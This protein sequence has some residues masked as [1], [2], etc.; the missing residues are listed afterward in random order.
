MSNY[1]FK[2]YTFKVLNIHMNK[3]N[4][5]Q[6]SNKVFNKIKIYCNYKETRT[7]YLSEL[8]AIF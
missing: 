7:F 1:T 3:I 6:K 2:N 5:F 4:Q 8:F